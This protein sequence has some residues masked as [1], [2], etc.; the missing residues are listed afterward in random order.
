L[1]KFIMKKIE[2][3]AT[4]NTINVDI[5]VFLRNYLAGNSRNSKVDIEDEF[6][7][8]LSDLELM[9]SF[10]V[11]D[12]DGK[13]VEW[14]RVQ[15]NVRPDLPSSIVLYAILDNSS[16]K[17]SIPFRDLLTGYNSPGALFALNEDG[18]YQKIEEI[19]QN[20]R[21]IIY[22]ETAGVRELQIKGSINKDSI[23]DD[24]YED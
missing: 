5:A 18:L 16:Y 17:K 1:T 22:K 9:Q 2:K 19:T 21:N 3:G 10:Q 20:N 6:S 12:S 8:L 4:A 15:S 13:N 24:Y 11:E 14:Y 23:L 7:N